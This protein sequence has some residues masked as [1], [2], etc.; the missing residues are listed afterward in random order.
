MRERNKKKH[1]KNSV[2]PSVFIYLLYRDLFQHALFMDLPLLNLRLV[3]L[4]NGTE[5]GLTSTDLCLYSAV[6]DST[7]LHHVFDIYAFSLSVFLIRRAGYSLIF[8]INYIIYY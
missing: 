6:I 1:K 8:L 4:Q 7:C 2:N 5:K 3:G